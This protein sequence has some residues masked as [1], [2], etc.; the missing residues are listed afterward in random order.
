MAGECPPFLAT[1]RKDR[2]CSGRPQRLRFHERAADTS[3]AEPRPRAYA[4]RPLQDDSV[5]GEWVATR[6]PS[7]CA[8][9]GDRGCSPVE[10]KREGKADDGTD[11]SAARH[12][13]S[14]AATYAPA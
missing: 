8:S 10:A 13:G 1:S 11:R 14:C 7:P 5:G 2:E 6:P 3:G 9:I 12:S 4:A